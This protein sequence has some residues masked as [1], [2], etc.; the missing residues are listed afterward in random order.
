MCPCVDLSLWVQ[1]LL[2]PKGDNRY[3]LSGVTSGWKLL[4]WEMGI[5]RQSSGRAASA[6]NLCHL[7][8]PPNPLL[9]FLFLFSAFL[10]S[11]LPT[12]LAFTSLSRLVL[13][14][15][16]AP[17]LAANF[18]II[19]WNGLLLDYGWLFLEGA[20]AVKSEHVFEDLTWHRFIVVPWGEYTLLFFL[21]M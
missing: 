15:Y 17:D 12:P 20:V 13:A 10:A 7:F 1:C 16:L 19:G 11:R 8:R 18:W 4:M 9:A 2:R 5:E 6:P 14:P 21:M 3:L